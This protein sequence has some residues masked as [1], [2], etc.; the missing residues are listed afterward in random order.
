MT[1]RSDDRLRA[2]ADLDFTPLQHPPAWAKPVRRL[3]RRMP[4]WVETVLV[5][6]ALGSGS[7]LLLL[8]FFSGVLLASPARTVYGVAVAALSIAVLVAVVLAFRA[9]NRRHGRLLIPVGPELPEF[10][11]ANDMV[12]G[13]TS[14]GAELPAPAG[15]EQAEQ[16]I[17]MR[18][19]PAPGS[20]WPPFV[21]GNRSFLAPKSADHDLDRDG[22]RPVTRDDGLFVAVPLGRR[23]PNIAL[24]RHDELSGSNLDLRT[25]YSMG[26]EFDRA[27]V[28][29]CPPGYERDALYL[30][31]PDVMAAMID[32]AAAAQWGAEVI[33]DWVFFWFPPSAQP[34]AVFEEDIRRA[35]LIVER[36]GAEL[37]KQAGNYR[38]ERV[39]DRAANL[40]AEPGRRVRTRIAP[41]T[42]IAIVGVVW[43]IAAPTLALLG[44]ALF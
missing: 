18:L 26:L 16:R 31:T 40:V 38:D 2:F 9:W 5:A 10:A 3:T 34:G 29:L 21:L 35:F 20:S 19:E 8:P 43:L 7:T 30:F 12:F 33:D 1:E 23:L 22:P 42:R 37:A 27:F 14:T 24:L 17:S 11:A 28:L 6:L 41:T 36:T 32:D 15:F 44:G 39:G 13:R 25:A 4:P